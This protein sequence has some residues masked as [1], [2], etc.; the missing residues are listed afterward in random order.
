MATR[1]VVEMRLGWRRALVG[2]PI[3]TRSRGSSSSAQRKRPN[4][5]LIPCP[6]CRK[7]NIMELTATTHA[8]RGHICFTCPNHGKDGSG[9]NFGYWK[10]R[11]VN[12]FER[13][14]LIGEEE[15]AHVKQLVCYS[16]NKKARRC[17]TA[18]SLLTGGPTRTQNVSQATC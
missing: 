12:Y 10:E 9:C 6:C 1:A 7:K 16:L 15:P 13:N 8:N 4:L 17:T 5:S 14:G 18:F 3:S 2:E 11:H